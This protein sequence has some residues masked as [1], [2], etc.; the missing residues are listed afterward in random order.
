[1]KLIYNTEVPVNK[2][3]GVRRESSLHPQ[4]NLSVTQESIEAA[5]N[6][7]TNVSEGGGG[8]GYEDDHLNDKDGNI[9]TSPLLLP[10]EGTGKV[11]H[12]FLI[13]PSA[14]PSQQDGEVPHSES[15]SCLDLGIIDYALILGPIMPIMTQPTHEWKVFDGIGLPV[16]ITVDKMKMNNNGDSRK[17][18]TMATEAAL[19]SGLFSPGNSIHGNVMNLNQDIKIWDRLPAVDLPDME[20]PSK[21][22]IF[23]NLIFSF[24]WCIKRKY[25]LLVC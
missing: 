8:G 23:Q 4:T 1:V 20:L 19:N 13:K 24:A 11:A 17:M 15:E 7:A 6:T 12:R 14:L 18:N 25:V 22:N 10:S 3:S 21:V 16:K 5:T 9:L 2:A